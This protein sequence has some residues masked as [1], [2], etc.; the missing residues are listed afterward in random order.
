MYRLITGITANPALR[1]FKP[2]E[3]NLGSITIDRGNKL[4]LHRAIGCEYISA[5]NPVLM[6]A[7][8]YNHD[9]QFVINSGAKHTAAY[10]IRYCSKRQN[11]VENYA[12]LSSASFAKAT[13]KTRI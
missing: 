8:K 6:S 10:V 4:R 3:V 13:N 11:S 7:L 2:Y 1:F 5:Y 12:A 9:A